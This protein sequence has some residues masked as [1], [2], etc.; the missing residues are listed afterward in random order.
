[1]S[2][3]HLVGGIRHHVLDRL[4]RAQIRDHRIE[5]SVGHNLMEA[6]RHD[7][8]DLRAIALDALA[9]Q[10]LELGVGVVADAV[11]LSCVMLDAVTLNGG[12][13][14]DRPPEK[15]MSMMSPEG[16]LGVW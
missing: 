8:G 4:D 14:Q 1:M 16:P 2:L 12:S 6:A 13:S 7:H 5:I 9:Q 11:S 15:D 3:R 10:L